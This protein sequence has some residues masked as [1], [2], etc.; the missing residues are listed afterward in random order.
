[1]PIALTVTQQK[2][3][4]IKMQEHLAV[5]M[6]APCCYF[7][8]YPYP[9]DGPSGSGHFNGVYI[10]AV[11][12]NFNASVQ[13][14]L[15]ERLNHM[16]CAGNNV[17]SRFHFKMKAVPLQRCEGGFQF[18][19]QDGLAE[20]H[21]MADCLR[22]SPVKNLWAKYDTYEAFLN[23]CQIRFSKNKQ[24]GNTTARVVRF[25]AYEALPLYIMIWLLR[26]LDWCESPTRQLMGEVEVME[27]N[28][29]PSGYD[30]ICWY[31]SLITW[32][33]K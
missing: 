27:T 15:M 17:D 2:E 18:L 31:S 3:Y 25:E 22:I 21:F 30:W 28:G 4:A 23:Q 10:Q 12:E 14:K 13:N 5:L 19:A 7:E 9:A 32:F 11:I 16:L 33:E 24:F 29:L 8:G 6:N 1:M 26:E 20:E